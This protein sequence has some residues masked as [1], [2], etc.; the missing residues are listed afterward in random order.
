MVKHSTLTLTHT[1]TLSF[2]PSYCLLANCSDGHSYCLR[3]RRI[4]AGGYLPR[5]IQLLES[6]AHFAPGCLPALLALSVFG[7]LSA[8]RALC[9]VAG[10]LCTL[11]AVA[12]ALPPCFV[13]SYSVQAD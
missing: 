6:L 7:C 2:S 1:C 5:W 12:R 8:L 10:A 9:A 3:V 4:Y 11:C 13:C